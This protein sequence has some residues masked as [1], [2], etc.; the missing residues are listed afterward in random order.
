MGET[1]GHFQDFW[2]LKLGTTADAGGDTRHQLS[3]AVVEM[4]IGPLAVAFC[5]LPQEHIAEEVVWKMRISECL[6]YDARFY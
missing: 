3:A 1:F 6:E 4:S 2:R 5:R